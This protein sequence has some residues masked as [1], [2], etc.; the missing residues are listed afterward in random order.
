T[1]GI[2]ARFNYAKLEIGLHRMMSALA[3]VAWLIIFTNNLY[4]YNAVY[5]SVAHFLGTERSV[6]ST[7]FTWGN[8]VLF[9]LVLYLSGALRK[10]IGY[11]FGETDDEI[12]G[13]ISNA[14]TFTTGNT[15][16]R[17]LV[18]NGT[19]AQAFSGA[20]TYNIK[21]L[22]IDNAAGA[23]L[24]TPISLVNYTG[25]GLILTNGKIYTSATNMLTLPELSTISGGSKNSFISGPVTKIFNANSQAD[26]NLAI[27]KDTLY[28]AVTIAPESIA[29]ASTF[30]AEYFNTAS[31]ND[32]AKQDGNFGKI[33]GNEYWNLQRISGNTNA[34][35]GFNWGESSQ[36]SSVENVRIARWD[37]SQWISEK[38][39]TAIGTGNYGTVST[40][41]IADF[42]TFTLG[43]Q[44]IVPLPVSWLFFTAK[45][46]KNATELNWATASEINN[47][48]FEIQRSLD[49]ENFTTIGFVNGNGTT[50]R[51]H[52][53]SY[54]DMENVQAEVVYY[55]LKQTDFNGTF[56]YSTIEAIRKKTNA[57]SD[58]SIYA[59]AQKYLHIEMNTNVSAS[60]Q[61]EILNMNGQVLQS[62]ILVTNAGNNV[63]TMNAQANKAGIY[64]LRISQNGTL[65]TRKF[66]LQ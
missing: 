13:N 43:S 7:S 37:G 51:K 27:G 30:K 32:V 48:G 5:Q 11:F 38:Q 4:V 26:I 42:G 16:T 1:E 14:G 62:E 19:T 3:V 59:D 17:K 56:E 54:A 9:F 8:I 44:Y 66:V 61:I 57:F 55:R 20:G 39:D 24:N 31:A 64:I 6:G 15:S 50:Q 49:G 63:L 58:V 28:R 65:Q 23:T 41:Y 45:N 2:A 46:T 22:E 40:K 29:T 52:F 25:S 12:G 53:Y 60:A 10:Y 18:L 35:I 47:D 21:T 33:S 34:A 36:V